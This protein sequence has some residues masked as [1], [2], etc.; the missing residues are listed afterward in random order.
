M[1]GDRGQFSGIDLPAAVGSRMGAIGNL[2]TE[3]LDLSAIGAEQQCA[4]RGTSD[5]E[6]DH[7]IHLSV[8]AC[9]CRTRGRYNLDVIERVA[10][11]GYRRIGVAVSGGADS[12]FLLRALRELGV[13]SA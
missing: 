5:V 8:L 12:V 10:H 2:R 1:G 3:V 6:R 7:A 9:M 13:A 4:G 11:Y